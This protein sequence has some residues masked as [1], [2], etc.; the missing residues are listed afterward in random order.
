MAQAISLQRKLISGQRTLPSAE[1]MVE[2]MSDAVLLV[3]PDMT[4]VRA[5]QA[6]QVLFG[7]SALSGQPVAS[8]PEGGEALALVM[9]RCF[10][11]SCGLS[12]PHF[13]LA[14]GNAGRVQEA[15]LSLT[16]V[17]DCLLAVLRLP[18][19]SQKLDREQRHRRAVRSFQMMASYLSHEI[20][21]PL[22]GIKGAAR[23]LAKS[24]SGEE[25]KTL[26]VLIESEAERIRRLT[27]KVAFFADI[28]PPSPAAINLHEVLEQVRAS[29]A[30]GFAAHVAILTDYD[31]SLPMVHADRDQMTQLFLNLVKNAA[32]AVPARGG[33]IVLRSFFQRGEAAGGGRRGYFG[34]SVE[35]NG[36]GFSEAMRAHMFEPFHTTK[37]G[38]SGVGLALCAKIVDDHDGLIEAD[39]APGRTALKVLLPIGAAKGGVSK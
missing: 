1:A 15:W 34:V 5:N 16:P 7:R 37:P 12:D 19:V 13:I 14:S 2:A 21:N 33:Q 23:L 24:A 22:S 10:E 8:L 39:S 31:P 28:A 25:D 9:R 26:A 30:A 38:G 6:A 36:Q 3:T 35:D 18:G 29:A 20:K 27:D 17:N 32:E 4:V 11:Q